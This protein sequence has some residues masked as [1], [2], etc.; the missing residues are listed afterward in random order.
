MS[1]GFTQIPGTDFHHTFSLVVKAS[2]VL[3]I[4]AISIHRNWSLQHLDVKNAFLNDILEKPIFMAQ[5]P[6]FV[7]PRFPDHVC[8]LKKALYAL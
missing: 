6:G 1:Q 5:P 4:L 3:V 7:V 2:I 8:R